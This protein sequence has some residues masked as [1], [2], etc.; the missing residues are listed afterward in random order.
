M[1]VISQTAVAGQHKNPARVILLVRASGA[2]PAERG[3]ARLA[4]LSQARDPGGAAWMTAH[5]ATCYTAVGGMADSRGRRMGEGADTSRGHFTGA[6]GRSRSV[7]TT[8]WCAGCGT[9]F[10]GQWWAA[11]DAGQDPVHLHAL[12]DEGFAGLNRNQ[13]PSCRAAYVVKE[14]I[15]VHRPEA[16]QL[17]LVVP[18]RRMHRA[19]QAR[20]ALI[21]AVADDPGARPPSYAR[22]PTLVA[23]VSGLRGLVG[24]VTR[25]STRPEPVEGGPGPE[26]DAHPAAD[27]DA[28]DPGVMA[29]SPGSPIDS[30]PPT[31]GAVGS[32]DMTMEVEPIAD[33]PPA[34]APEA[35]AEPQGLIAAL[36]HHGPADFEEG[37]PEDATGRWHDAWS[38]DG[39]EAREPDGAVEHEPTRVSRMVTPRARLPEGRGTRLVVDDGEVLA[40]CRVPSADH[41]DRLLTDD[42]ELRFQLHRTPHGP[43]L[44][45]TLVPPDPGE[46]VCWPIDP[47]GEGEALDVLAR[48]FAVIIEAIDGEGALVGRRVF[49]PPLARNVA[50]ARLQVERQGGSPVA[51]RDAV[52]AGAVDRVGQLRHNFREDA[53]A[54]CRSVSEAHLALSIIG[55][56]TE[57]ERE[58][59][60]YE[61]QSFPR[62]WFEAIVR[63]VLTAA[64]DFGLMPA[65]HLEPRAIEMGLAGDPRSLVSRALSG[66]AEL[67]LSTSL[68]G[69]D[70]DP[71]DNYENWERLL[72]RAEGLGLAVDAGLRGLALSAMEAA[73]H[74]AEAA[75]ASDEPIELDLD[76]AIELESIDEPGPLEPIPEAPD[77]QTEPL[78][79]L[80]DSALV[81]LLDEAGQRASAAA[82][83]LQ[84]GE[85]GY[86]APVA[87]A[88]LEMKPTE[89]IRVLP[90]G[91]A[92]ADAL[93]GHLAGALRS[94]SVPLR[95]AVTL[96]MAE[97]R[98]PE[99]ILALVDQLLDA[100]DGGWR[101]LAVALAGYGADVRH[102]VA[103]LPLEGEGLERAAQVLARFSPAVRETVFDAGARRAPRVRHC[104]EH[105]G[106]LADAGPVTPA[107]AQRLEEALSAL[108][109]PDTRASTSAIGGRDRS[110]R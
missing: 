13:C 21:A 105:A 23:G 81:G 103:G 45:L 67:N 106:R 96:F 16:G 28:S 56:W 32:E 62:V 10:G 46:L 5:G 84:R 79:D 95:R 39:A 18:P 60:L 76:D 11:I 20:A 107:F 35:P 59:Y 19:Q 64:V 99:A 2:W 93:A 92:Q 89:L 61:I 29:T 41:A 1:G 50:A 33:R 94:P 90:L 97:A 87:A 73:R 108:A 22:E 72:T 110:L 25:V 42:A 71:I 53:F 91:L 31:T 17:L 70:L 7:T 48:R 109:A 65:A 101:P 98:R 83:L 24:E 63:R 57:P 86:A 36:M 40:L 47:V 15:V 104:L 68:K 55:F 78:T 49:D 69:N 75:D 14:P 74:A 34:E 9:W 100:R 38:L 54:G 82:V 12:L 37:P 8:I 58:A 88:L 51:A 26:P 102:I 77:D 3:D 27:P 44:S 30:L 6:A 43:A 66:F 4:A 85:P 80:I 52:A